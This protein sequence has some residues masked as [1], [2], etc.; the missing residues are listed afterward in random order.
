MYTY[1][2]VCIYIYI[3]THTYIYI[4]ICIM[5]VVCDLMKIWLSDILQTFAAGLERLDEESQRQ[6]LGLKRR[7]KGAE[8][9]RTKEWSMGKP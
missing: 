1:V 7:R 9:A 8:E 4:Y 2:S 6:R 3:Y 5:Y